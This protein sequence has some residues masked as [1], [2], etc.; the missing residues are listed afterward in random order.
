MLCEKHRCERPL[1][2]RL[3]FPTSRQRVPN[4][5]SFK[6]LIPDKISR[7]STPPSGGPNSF[8]LRRLRKT[9]SAIKRAIR[10]SL[11]RHSHCRT[12]RLPLRDG[13][14]APEHRRIFGSGTEFDLSLVFRRP[15]GTFHVKQNQI[16]FNSRVATRLFRFLQSPIMTRGHSFFQSQLTSF[17]IFLRCHVHSA[18]VGTDGTAWR[19]SIG[20]NV[21]EQHCQFAL[22][23]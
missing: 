13:I 16:A 23:L 11:Y 21:T 3:W 19:H 4:R 1:F 10:T 15:Y 20:L 9:L 22:F 5:L 2:S 6:P 14:P 7:P 12:S 8:P 18:S 17:E